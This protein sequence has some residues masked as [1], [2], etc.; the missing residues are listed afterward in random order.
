LTERRVRVRRF[1]DGTPVAQGVVDVGKKLRP[2]LVE[3]DC[4]LWVEPAP[5]RLDCEWTALKML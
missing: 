4:V 3:R 2:N 5:E 1:D